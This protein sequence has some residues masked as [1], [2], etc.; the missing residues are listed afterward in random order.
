[1][2]ED[3]DLRT[4]RCEVIERAI[5]AETLASA[6]ICQHYF[7]RCYLPF[8]LEVLYD[9]YFSFSL[10]RRVLEKVVDH[11]DLGA[12]IQDL[13]RLG[14]I[15]N[16][17]AHCGTEVYAIATGEGGVPDPRRPDRPIDFA[18]LHAEFIEI[19]PRV[20]EFLRD[21]FVSKGG[22]LSDEPPSPA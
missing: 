19:A 3:G 14:T 1:M 15:R 7:N 12:R 16:Y 22:Q 17:F 4:C 2:P 8:M 13:N 11:P 9:E 18:A 10:K 20:E 6:I 21:V 5:N